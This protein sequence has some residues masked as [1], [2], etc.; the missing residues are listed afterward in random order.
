MTCPSDAPS[1]RRSD[2]GRPI[3]R[4]GCTGDGMAPSVSTLWTRPTIPTSR[5]RPRRRSRVSNCKS[6]ALLNAGADAQVLYDVTRA[7]NRLQNCW[8]P[9]GINHEFSW[10]R[11]RTPLGI[12]ARKE[13][14]THE[15][16]PDL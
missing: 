11:A 4:C 7:Y 6:V 8:A 3:R 10:A 5:Q 12:V 16:T 15:L 1:P 14:S 9:Q 13:V 2:Q